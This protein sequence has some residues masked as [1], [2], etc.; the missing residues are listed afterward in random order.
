MK[1]ERTEKN[2]E[3][4]PE[5]EKIR[6]GRDVREKDEEEQEG[7]KEGRLRRDE[8]GRIKETDSSV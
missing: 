5:S 1:K 2:R 6:N 8:G 4:S 3:K 7:L